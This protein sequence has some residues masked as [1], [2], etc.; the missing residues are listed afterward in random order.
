MPAGVELVDRILQPHPEPLL[1][2]NSVPRQQVAEE[3]AK[4]PHIVS[5]RHRPRAPGDQRLD[6]PIHIG[7]GQLPCWLA[8]QLQKPVQ[9]GIV[10]L[11]R[12]RAEVARHHAGD[13]AADTPG[14]KRPRLLGLSGR[15]RNR[16]SSLDKP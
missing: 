13:P 9:S 5:T 7:G 14:L 1:D 10:V 12:E 11:D 3:L 2:L 16:R 4:R 6:H 8:C 15:H